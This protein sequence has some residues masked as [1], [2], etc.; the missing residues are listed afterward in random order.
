MESRRPEKPPPSTTLGIL[1]CLGGLKL[2]EDYCSGSLLTSDKYEGK[3][4]IR[5]Y[6]SGSRTMSA[7][8]VEKR[9]Q[10]GGGRIG[11]FA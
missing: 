7:T 11:A 4:E 6:K 2:A 8:G 9:L 3:Q 10:S 1:L 5:Q